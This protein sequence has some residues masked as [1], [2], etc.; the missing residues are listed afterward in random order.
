MKKLLFVML[1]SAA[2]ALGATCPDA[3]IPGAQLFP[4]SPLY[5]YRT[6]TGF[7]LSSGCTGTGTL[8]YLWTQTSGPS[9]LALANTTTTTVST[10]SGVAD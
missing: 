6:G 3:P 7:S 8:S 10:F 4:G 2:A 5:T 9:T 1:A